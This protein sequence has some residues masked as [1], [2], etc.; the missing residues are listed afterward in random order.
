MTHEQ[1]MEM[2]YPRRVCADCGQFYNL[3]EFRNRDYTLRST[4]SQCA[5]AHN[6]T[7]KKNIVK[8]KKQT[9]NYVSN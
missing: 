6:T 1:R 7:G 8:P 2:A 3:S 5:K 4:C 9:K